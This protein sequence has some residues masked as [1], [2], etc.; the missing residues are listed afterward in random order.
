MWCEVTDNWRSFRSNN[1][2]YPG[3][4]W[5]SFGD[6]KELSLTTV[7]VTHW[8]LGWAPVWKWNGLYFWNIFCPEGIHISCGYMNPQ[9]SHQVNT[10]LWRN[11]NRNRKTFDWKYRLKS[12]VVSRTALAA[13]VEHVRPLCLPPH[14]PL[15]IYPNGDDGCYIGNY[16]QFVPITHRPRCSGVVNSNQNPKWRCAKPNRYIIWLN[17]FR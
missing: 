3:N 5:L 17:W 14:T 10:S 6:I 15:E 8:Y 12:N 2:V 13:F 11:V 1:L 9:V 7:P 16:I 4:C